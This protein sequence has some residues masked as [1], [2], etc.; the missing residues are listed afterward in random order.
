M[1]GNVRSLESGGPM[2]ELQF[3]R[4]WSIFLDMQI[5][6][7]YSQPV[8]ERVIPTEGKGLL[9]PATWEDQ[10]GEVCRGETAAP[11]K[12]DDLRTYRISKK[13]T[14]RDHDVW[15]AGKG[16]SCGCGDL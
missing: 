1:Q 11:H 5:S 7:L 13:N 2:S 4:F 15:L 14:W 9:N 6:F 8:P 12:E 16:G 10:P 3:L